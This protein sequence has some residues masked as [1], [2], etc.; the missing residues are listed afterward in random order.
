MSRAGRIA[1]L[2]EIPEESTFLFRVAGADGIQEAIL[3]R[4]AGEVTGWLNYCRHFTHITLDKGDGATMRDGEVVCVNHGAMFA[5]DTGRCTFGPCE[6]AYLV[7]IDISVEDGVVYLADPD[8]Q[9]VGVGPIETD[10]VDLS[11]TSNLE[12]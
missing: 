5:A 2:T 3:V 1:A 4:H 12:F 9:F 8:Y 7:D 11:S 6:G 10:P